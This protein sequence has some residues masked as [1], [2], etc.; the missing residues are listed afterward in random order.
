ME[1][2]TKEFTGV[3][4][5]KDANLDLY[6]GEVHAL[7]GEN[8]AGKS[9]LMKILTGIYKKNSGKITYL[10][11]EI[12]LK[13]PKEAQEAGI[14]IVHQELNMMNHLSV[15][16][17]IFIGRE[18]KSFGFWLDDKTINQKAAKLFEKLGISIH[19]KE[20]IGNLTVGKQQM[21]EIAKA[22]SYNA[23]IIIFDEPTA[24]LTEAEISELFRMIEELKEKGVGMIYISHRMDEIEK[25]TDRVTVMRD[26]EYIGTVNTHDTTKEE[27][28]NMMV[29]RVIYETPKTESAVKED[30]PVVLKAE[31]ITMSPSVKN[32]SF[33]L[34][35]GEILGFA[36]LMGAGRTELARAIF[37]ADK[38]EKGTVFI[39][40][41]RVEINSPMDAVKNGIGYLSE[42][43]KRFGVAV[44]L[45]VSENSVL[46]ALSQFSEFGFVND[47]LAHRTSKEY[48]EKLKTKTPSVHQLV[49]N[50]SGGNQQKVVI[51]KW[52]IQNSDILI[53]DEPTRGIDVGAKSEIY[54]LMN[55][56][57]QMGKSII[58]ISSELTEVLRLSDRIIVMCEGRITGELDIK[59]ATQE[60]IMRL[61]TLREQTV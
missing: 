10:G 54:T 51:A 38:M 50:L 29:G 47:S 58:M 48:C 5:L 16:E 49:R 21:V 8:G 42:D 28:I 20:I 4:A 46:T 60:E 52:L 31:G 3:K 25:I 17:N 36:G 13:N 18:E 61:A 24:A 23:R 2:I 35:K 1:H 15:A 41:K 9:T 39:H 26:G 14:I 57:A 59:D 27:I 43:R 53:F 6:P 37:G 55:E 19:P 32:A 33:S 7:M 11:K 45:S 34:R 30:A 12:E 40:G 56:L 44:D 22:I